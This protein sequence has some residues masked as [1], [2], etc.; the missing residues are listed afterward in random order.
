[1]CGSGLLR[2]LGR[3][4]PNL[5]ILTFHRVV[6]DEEK[7]RSLNTPMMV[8]E[9]QFDS[10]LKAIRKYAYPVSL[11]DAVKRIRQG[12]DFRPGTLAITFDDGYY[13]FYLRAFPLLRQYQIPATIFLTTGVIGQ[14]NEYLWWD[15]F[16]YYAGVCHEKPCQASE[17]A[18]SELQYAL[19][20]IARLPD[21]R[22]E[23]AEAEI[24]EALNRLTPGERDRFIGMIRSAVP[25][26]SPRPQLMLTWD[27]IREISG[28]VEIANHTV[29]HNLLDRLDAASVREEI[30]GANERIKQ[31]TGL[32][33]HG[34][35]YPAGVYNPEVA[36][37]AGE[38]G[39]EYAVTTRFANNSRQSNLMSLDRKDAGYLFIGDR[40]EPSY[41]KVTVSGL[42][43]RFRKDYTDSPGVLSSKSMLDES[44]DDAE[45]APLV[46][47]VIYHLAV[48]GLENG[49]VNLINR[50]PAERFRH[51][52]IC[53]TD[54]T[55]FRNRIS[56]PDVDVYVLHKRP[57]KDLRI[58]LELFKLFRQLRPD[59][60]HTRNLSTLEA[61]LPALLAGVPHRVHGEHGRDISDL[62]GTSRKYRLLR[63]LFS[64]LVQR[65]IALSLDLDSY[66]RDRVGISAGKITH[67]CNGVDIEKFRPPREQ[68]MDILPGNFS[69]ADRVVVGT[70]GRMEAVKD[71]LNLAKAF[72]QLVEV[73]PDGGANLRLVMIGDGALR[74][75][76]LSLLREAGLEDIV[77][78]PGERDNVPELLG[79]MDIFVLPSLAEG[80]SNTILEAMATGLPVVATD[81]GGNSE[82][83]LDGETGFL[84][85]RS[86]PA[87]LAAAIRRYVDDTGLRHAHGAHAQQRC[88]TEFSISVMVKN[89]QDLYDALL[90][91]HRKPAIASA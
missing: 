22:T 29:N 18:S 73:H 11:A 86:D 7:S 45:H 38:C 10:L 43:D 82:L 64:P 83:V 56:K 14:Q 12:G 61:Q 74:Q 6:T 49:L 48:G 41:Y 80:I 40:L 32:R 4:G 5:T 55:D 3:F 51:A 71:Q 62:D 1:M 27:N 33:C 89:Y 57:G 79:S 75:P 58:Y 90:P 59:I 72:I 23:A 13:D 54:Y 24:R 81:V 36:K 28:H 84:V 9:G 19:R 35:A 8:T 20:L 42:L 85:P 87:A 78:L 37:I 26:N 21:N 68:D 15:E 69:G 17:D 66:L 47:H 25:E 60:V 70:V 46:V 77:W 53:L 44:L 39:I 34:M 76:A 50:L 30:T 16:D 88:E 52:I 2:M 63:R 67:I 91:E 31:E 65:Y